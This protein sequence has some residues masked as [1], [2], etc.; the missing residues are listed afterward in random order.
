M[1]YRPLGDG[2]P[3]V[4]VVGL[5]CNQFGGRVDEAGTRRII[6]AALESGITLVDTADVYGSRGGSETFIGSALLGRRDRVVL[7]TKFGGAPMFD[8]EDAPCGTRPY[9]RRAVEASLRRLRTDWIDLYQYHHHDGVTPLEETLGALNELVEEGTVR[10]I[11]SSNLTSAQVEEA[12]RIAR[13]RGWAR[14]VSAQNKYSLAWREAEEALLPT[15]RRLGIGMLPYHPLEQGLL[16]GKYRRD[17][18]LPSRPRLVGP[19]QPLRTDAWDEIDALARYGEERGRTL[20]EV[21]IAGLA[22]QPTIGSVIA[23]AT[24]PEQVGAN[25]AAGE[26]E[27]TQDDL[28]ELRRVLGA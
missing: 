22:A 24:E 11:G 25:A 10:H 8:D 5:G 16:T 15:C 14:F 3:E 7:A 18:P 4:S 23:G 6:D 17:G 19:P 20:L 21:A 28:A 9:I 27:P 1:R 26:W 2:G 12:D 13:E